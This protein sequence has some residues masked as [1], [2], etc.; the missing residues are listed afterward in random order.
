MDNVGN[1]IIESI[2]FALNYKA[3]HA[4]PAFWG[5]VS[6]LNVF[7]HS[8]KPS[9]TSPPLSGEGSHIAMRTF[10]AQHAFTR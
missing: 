3:G 2:I 5:S 7:D 8:A 10:L 9:L 1:I 6:F 4:Y